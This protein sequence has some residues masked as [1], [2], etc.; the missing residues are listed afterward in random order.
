MTARPSG[1]N[2]S[3]RVR[4]ALGLV[5]VFTGWAAG[6]LTCRRISA[7]FRDEKLAQRL[8]GGTPIRPAFLQ[9]VKQCTEQNPSADRLDAAMLEA[10]SKAWDQNP[11][12]SNP[13]HGYVVSYFAWHWQLSGHR[14][15]PSEK[16]IAELAPSLDRGNWPRANTEL[17][18]L[19]LIERLPP[20]GT[21]ARGLA[22]I[23]FLGWIP[24]S[25][26][27]G[28]DSRPFARQL[29]G[30]QGVFARPWRA[31]ALREIGSDNRLGTSAAYLAVAVDPND[32]LPKVSRVM[33]I[34]LASSRAKA[35]MRWS[36][37]G[38]PS[39]APDD[40]NRL[41]E[42]GYALSR[43]GPAAESYSAPIIAMLDQR[44]ERPAP[45]FGL[46][47]AEPTEFCR[48]ARYIGGRV[49]QAAQAKPFC[50]S[51][52]QGGDGAPRPL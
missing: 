6:L 23:A 41:I 39:I 42:L 12:G 14:C 36:G 24:P 38:T 18:E 25:E 11:T 45:P 50:S 13:V 3:R 19:R 26:L 29:L 4:L 20:S 33:A 32:A 52:F 22:S 34:K 37:L 48:M 40:G 1:S 8:D 30:D 2:S 49:A 15:R 43:A 9:D 47:P 31:V 27:G 17:N 35:K 21:R 7:A 51:G 5:L 28:E 10:D 44:I 16:I 46:L